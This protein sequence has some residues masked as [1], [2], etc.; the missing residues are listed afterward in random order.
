MQQYEER[1]PSKWMKQ[2]KSFMNAVNINL[3]SYTTWNTSRSMRL[4]REYK[5]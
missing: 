5:T 3:L 1:K 2:I 4:K